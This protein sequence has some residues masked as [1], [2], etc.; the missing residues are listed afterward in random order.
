MGAVAKHRAGDNEQPV[1][2][3]AEGARV[4]VTALSRGSVRGTDAGI[5]LNGDARSVGEA[6]W[7]LGLQASRRVTIRLLREHLVTGAAPQ[8]VGKAC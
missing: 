5:V 8:R 6:F 2:D 4:A 7:S 1:A 3:R